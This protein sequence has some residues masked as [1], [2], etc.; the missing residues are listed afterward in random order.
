MSLGPFTKLTVISVSGNVYHASTAKIPADGQFCWYA[1]EPVGQDRDASFARPYREA[2]DVSE[3][4][5]RWIRGY[6]DAESP[7]V[8]AMRAAQAM[9][10]PPTWM[11][12]LPPQ[13]GRL[14]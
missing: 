6:H 13:S 7:D 8:H 11:R 1:D 3:E 4:G 10:P 5:S 12:T 14:R 2:V 9:M